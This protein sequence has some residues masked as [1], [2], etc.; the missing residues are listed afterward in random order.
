MRRLL[1]FLAFMFIVLTVLLGLGFNRLVDGT[2]RPWAESRTATALQAEVRLDRLEL[3][4]GRLELTG[5]QVTRPGELR[6]RVEQVEVRFS[7]A[8]LWRRRLDAVVVRQP[9]LEWQVTGADGGEPVLW[10]SQP[11]LQ[12]GAWTV[13]DGR[14]LLVLGQDRLLLRQL[15]AAGNLDSPFT[16]NASALLGSEPGE[17]LACSGHGLWEGRPELTITSLL[18]SGNSLL[19]APVTITPGSESFEVILT[20]AQL[21]DVAATRLL[22]SS[23]VRPPGRRNWPGG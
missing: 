15:E 2:L 9:E 5:V 7:F 20:L 4:W 6:L 8:G 13:E 10:P 3:K 17:A 22:A 1:I 16:V 11:P 19:Q 12:V 21:D 18:W 23:S 14:L